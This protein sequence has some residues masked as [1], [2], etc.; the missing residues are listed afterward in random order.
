M[1][2][3]LAAVLVLIGCSTVAGG[4]DPE[5]A[6]LPAP[7]PEDGG[8]RLRLIVATEA[9]DGNDTFS[10]QVDLVNTTDR[11][12]LLTADWPYDAGKGDFRDYL[13]ASVSIETYPPIERWLGQTMAPHRTAPQPRY[14]LQAK[15]TLTLNWQAGDRRLKNRVVRPLDVQNPQFPTDGL[16]SVH[17]VAVVRTPDGDVLLR[18]NEQQ[19]PIGGSQQ[20]PRHTVASVSYVNAEARTA[21]LSLGTLHKISIGDRFLIATPNFLGDPNYGWRLTVASTN[22]TECTG[23]LTPADHRG[24][25]APSTKPRLPERGAIAT[26]IAKEP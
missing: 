15:S 21:N 16:Y 20:V 5:S 25:D 14:E 2:R 8:L 18:S 24:R 10:V 1:N 7:G 12:I 6:L 26:L 23:T 11:P 4:A 3:R 9:R 19:V 22:P 13:E 17:A